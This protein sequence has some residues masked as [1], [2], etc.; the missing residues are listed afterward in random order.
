MATGVSPNIPDFT[1]YGGSSASSSEDAAGQ[2]FYA[3]SGWYKGVFGTYV[4]CVTPTAVKNIPLTPQPTS[5]GV[6]EADGK[7]LALTSTTEDK[8]FVR[9]RIAEYQMPVSGAT[10]LYGEAAD[11]QARDA[12]AALQAR[13]GRLEAEETADDKR[14]ADQEK[15]IKALEVHD[16]DVDARIAALLAAAPGGITL[17]DVRSYLWNDRFTVDLLYDI[18]MNRKDAGVRG[19]IKALVTEVLAEQKR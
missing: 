7:G 16:R 1:V 8:K 3:N 10:V 4:F 14:D 9:Y 18:L 15:R 19:A 11:Q 6:L 5:R 2:V 17:N 12:I 13:V